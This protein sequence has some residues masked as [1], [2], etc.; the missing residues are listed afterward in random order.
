[1]LTWIKATASMAMPI[2]SC[3]SNAKFLARTRAARWCARKISRASRTNKSR[4]A[5][6]LDIGLIIGGGLVFVRDARRFNL[7][8]AYRQAPKGAWHVS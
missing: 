5:D 6:T 3:L 7:E 8:L 2:Y 1:M 4:L